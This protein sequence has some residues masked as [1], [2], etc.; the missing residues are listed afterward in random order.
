[1][2][3]RDKVNDLVEMCQQG[4]SNEAFEKHYA[5][6]C[7]KIEATGD[8][9]EGKEACRAHH[10]QWEDAVSEVHSAEVPL[11]MVDGDTAVINWKMDV[12]FKDGSRFQM[13][14]I[15]VQQWENGKMKKEQ[16]YYDA[17]PMMAGKQEG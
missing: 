15:A 3:T 9:V 8:R 12:S 5:D 11:V 13:D 2:S 17:S 14:E 4:Q 16:F 1:M 6:D 7:L 10:K